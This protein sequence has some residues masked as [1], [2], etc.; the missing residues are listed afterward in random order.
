MDDNALPAFSAHRLPGENA[1]AWLIAILAAGGAVL[2]LVCALAS[3]AP[4]W[5]PGA[6]PAPEPALRGTLLPEDQ[7]LPRQAADEPR[8][9]H[10]PTMH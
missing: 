9:N 2:A 8:W 5:L 3:F 1:P 10:P 4:F 7:R 6:G